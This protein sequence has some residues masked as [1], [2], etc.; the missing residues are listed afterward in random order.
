[1]KPGDFPIGSPESRATARLIAQRQESDRKQAWLA[2]EKKVV[3]FP[4]LG[5]PSLTPNKPC[6]SEWFESKD[7]SK[8]LCCI[9]WVPH[10]MSAE[11]AARIVFPEGL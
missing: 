7:A 1:M 10:D 11:E 2:R 8:K 6:R 4:I 5:P 9:L 3:A